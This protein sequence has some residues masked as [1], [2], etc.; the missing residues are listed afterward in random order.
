MAPHSPQWRCL[1]SLQTRDASMLV[2]VVLL[3]VPLLPGQPSS[4]SLA[5]RGLR[6]KSYFFIFTCL[7]Y[8]F[9]DAL[10]YENAPG[11]LC[12]AKEN[13]GFDQLCL[14]LR[15]GVVSL[16]PLVYNV[17][18]K[19]CRLK[20]CPVGS[21]SGGRC[22]EVLRQLLRVSLFPPPLALC[23]YSSASVFLQRYSSSP[24][25][26]FTV[27]WRSF[28]GNT[29]HNGNAFDSRYE[30]MRHC[31][32]LTV[33]A[34]EHGLI[35]LSMYH[36]SFGCWLSGWWN[37]GWKRFIKCALFAR[38]FLERLQTHNCVTCSFVLVQPYLF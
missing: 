18:P 24:R 16:F 23:G 26:V 37:S 13:G 31:A 28:V 19:R 22:Y 21:G 32:V 3:R 30:Q 7:E 20:I 4:S 29:S 34:Q 25:C 10:K 38:C 15:T 14:L 9:T 5:R 11:S 33:F 36:L 12:G 6:P 1:R 8:T 35:L 2:L 27:A 17:V